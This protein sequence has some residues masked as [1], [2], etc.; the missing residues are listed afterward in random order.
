MRELKGHSLVGYGTAKGGARASWAVSAASAERLEPAYHAATA[1]DVERAVGLAAEV[2]PE[3]AAASPAT[4]AAFLRAVAGELEAR[5]DEVIARAEQETAL[6]APRLQGELAR[7]CSQV[8]LFA[9]LVE[10]G[11]RVDARIDKGDPE[12]KP[13]PKPDVRS[14]RRPLGPV[15]VFG[16]SN[17]PLAFSVAGGDTASALAAG[18]PVVCKA[19]P[20]HPG[21]SELAGRVLLDAARACGLP[22]G[23]FS[24]L[25]DDGYEVGQE[26]VQHPKVKAIGFTGSRAGGE[27]LMRL[28]ATRPEPIPVY[29]EMSSVNPVFVLPQ[30]LRA[31]AEAIADGLHGSFT[32]G[33]GQFCTSPGVVLLEAG[34]AGDALRERLVAKTSE[35]SGDT[36]LTPGICEA[37]G[38]GLERMKTAGAQRVGQGQEGTSS[39]SGRAVVWEVDVGDVAKNP[40]LLHEVFGPSTL[41]VRYQGKDELLNFAAALEGQLTATLQGE[42]D[43]LRDYKPLI[44]LLERKV[45]RLIVNQFPTGVEVGHA[46][47]H[48]GPFPATSDGR[49][50]SVGTHAIERFTR[51]VAYQNFPQS[52]LPRELRDG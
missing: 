46:M 11:S 45:G 23:V 12:R 40:E 35:A 34:T 6:G 29:A 7:T 33:V 30:A 48:G 49:S 47:V 14:V 18:C 16:A 25:F 32:L 52:L 5:K 31:R 13:T 8:R 43:E 4:R 17:F 24:L 2:F 27:A 15:V 10:E 9:D 26:L 20:A 38:R 41:L 1:D 3:Y 22:E 28:A 36:M 44:D 39:S 37:Y 21:T 19:H 50:T 51:Y 42:S